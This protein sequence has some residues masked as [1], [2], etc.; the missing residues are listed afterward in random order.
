MRKKKAPVSLATALAISVL[1]VPGGPYSRIPRGGC[2]HIN[3]HN[4]NTSWAARKSVFMVSGQ[5]QHKLGC[6]EARNFGSRKYRDCS[7]HIEKV[8]VLINCAFTAQLICAF[9]FANAKAG[10]LMTWLIYLCYITFFLKL[11]KLLLSPS[12]LS[13]FLL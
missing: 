7:I 1:P 6:I 3:N 11:D 13:S 4:M 5:V 12:T 9:V 2:Q 10:F 8:I